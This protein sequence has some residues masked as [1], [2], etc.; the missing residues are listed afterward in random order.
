MLFQKKCLPFA[1]TLFVCAALFATGCNLKS[2]PH[3]DYDLRSPQRARLGKA[4]S[5][6]SGI[7][8]DSAK[9][10]SLLAISD[11]K[12]KVYR[13]EM[14]KVKLE[15]HTENVV[16]SASDLEDIVKVDSSIFLLRSKGIIIEVPDKA[17]DTSGVKTYTIPLAGTNDFETLYHDKS[18]NSLVLLCKACA[19]EKGKG[20]RTAY[21]FDLATR[22]FD[23]TEFFEINKNEV[24][25][26]LKDDGAKLDPSAAAIHPISKRLYILSSAGNLLVVTDTRGKVME[27]YRLAQNDY[28]QAEGIAFAPNGDMFISNEAKAGG[29]PTLLR[30]TYQ[31]TE[32]KK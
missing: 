17:K 14:K 5:E 27:A 25:T 23:S 7:C 18:V 13:L 2:P 21:R 31:R 8:Y 10:S 3:K 16:P 29:P 9:D 12:E 32:K 22:T 24:K 6:V 15:E 20:V 19:H 4:L 26:L 1:F 11:S 30:F 28:P